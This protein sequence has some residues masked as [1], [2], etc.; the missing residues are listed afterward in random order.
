MHIIYVYTD[1]TIFGTVNIVYL[2]FL[3]KTYIYIHTY[4]HTH[5]C[6][7]TAYMYVRT[8][9]RRVLDSASTEYMP[10]LTSAP[11]AAR[12]APVQL[13]MPNSDCDFAAE[14]VCVLP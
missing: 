6:M 14:R 12:G 4:T 5:T 2:L 8:S 11:G 1:V 3:T 9:R 13:P 10:T 7:H